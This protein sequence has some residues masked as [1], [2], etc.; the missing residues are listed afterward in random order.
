MA[1]GSIQK[2]TVL[3]ELQGTL[4]LGIPI[5]AAFL[6][7]Q[8]LG[9]IDVVM[10]GNLSAKDLAAV[11]IGRSLFM[12]ILVSMLGVLIAINP[13]VA[14]FYGARKIDQIGKTVWQGLLVSQ[15]L[16]FPCVLLVRNLEFVMNFMNITPEIIPISLGYLDAISWCLPAAFAYLVL[17]FFQEGISIPRPNLYFAIMA[18]PVNLLGNWLLMYG[19]LGFPRLGAVG[20]G[21]TTTIVWWSMLAGM[22]TISF[23]MHHLQQFRVFREISLPNWKHIKEILRT[24]IPNG[25]S[26]G[27]EVG[28]FAVAALIIGSM[29]V[30]TMGGHMI[31]VNV[32]SIVFMIPLG[33]SFATTSKVGF[34]PE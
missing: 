11:A 32:A 14:Q 28:M 22:L 19:N 18:I 12:P 29:G 2:D 6:A 5:V 13:I 24:G 8:S 1:T 16:A 26:L 10:A 30:I 9:F 23:R 15:M 4:S 34:R 21:W 25:I 20:A 27:M 31:A 33:L 7:Q 3:K 17:R